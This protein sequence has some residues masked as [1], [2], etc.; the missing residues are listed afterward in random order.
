[1]KSEPPKKKKKKNRSDAFQPHV[2]GSGEEIKQRWGGR[3]AAVKAE[4]ISG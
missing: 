3:Q 2:V 4:Q 1:M